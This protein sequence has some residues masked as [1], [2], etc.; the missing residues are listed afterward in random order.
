MGL[1]SVFLDH[2]EY[3]GDVFPIFAVTDNDPAAALRRL[4]YD[5][6]PP[7]SLQALDDP[8]VI[9]TTSVDNYAAISQQLTAGNIAHCFFG[10]IEGVEE[11]NYPVVSLA[12]LD[13]TYAD[14]LGNTIEWEGDTAPDIQVFFGQSG[15]NGR[16]PIK[17][18]NNRLTIGKGVQLT[19]RCRVL[20]RGSGSA[21][22]IGSHNWIGGDMELAINSASYFR[23]G[24]RC[25][26]ESLS[27]VTHDGGIS[28]GDDCMLSVRVNMQQSDSH[29][30]FD[31]GSGQ[32]INSGRNI[33]I[34][35]HVWVGFEAFL[36]G[37]CTI[38]ND[39]IVGAR[40]VTSGRFSDGV[41]L[42]GSPARVVREGVTWRKDDLSRSPVL[43][44]VSD[45]KLY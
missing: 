31:A 17:A 26:F 22:Q 25:T 11:A 7:A 37:G 1:G 9:V 21:V 36:L 45:C 35:N 32:R 38:G 6:L 5:Y 23:T 15:L 24:E 28:V 20:F 13:G 19:G 8:F 29:P 44:H 39:C 30:I 34:G 16:P 42:A 43:S 4:A 40:A 14:H 18:R 3:L 33:T 12:S 2:H 41:V 27:V 10:E